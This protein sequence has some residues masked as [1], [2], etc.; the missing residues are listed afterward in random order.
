MQQVVAWR[1]HFS[2]RWE[3]QQGLQMIKKMIVDS[4][5]ELKYQ[6]VELEGKIPSSIH[7]SHRRGSS[8]QDKII[9]RSYLFIS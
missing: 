8:K 7:L 3:L 4:K 5:F 1:Q 6:L 2:K 9:F